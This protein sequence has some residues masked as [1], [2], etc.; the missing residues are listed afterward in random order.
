MKKSAVICDLDGTLC[1]NRHRLHFIEGTGKKDWKSFNE[2]CIHDVPNRW[3]VEILKGLKHS[4]EPI[5]ITGRSED[6]FDHTTW[7]I[8]KYLDDLKDT[9]GNLSY[10][11]YMRLNGDFRPDTEVKK[12][13][14]EQ[15]VSKDFDVLFALEDRKSVAQMWRGLGLT[16]LH[17]AEGE[18]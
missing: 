13:I 12:A 3:C 11:L 5:F 9:S 10:S 4:Y 8:R 1:D 18:F 2:G 6:Y 14:Y 17:C 7:W 16:V 15:Y